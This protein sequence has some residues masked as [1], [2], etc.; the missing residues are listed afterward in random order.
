MRI[1]SIVSIPSHEDHLFLP[2]TLGKKH[3]VLLTVVHYQE[4][5]GEDPLPNSYSYNKRGNF[6]EE[7]YLKITF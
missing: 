2:Y 4:S 5:L 1:L 7:K 3:R 6:N